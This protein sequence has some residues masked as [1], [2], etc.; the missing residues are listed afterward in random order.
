MNKNVKGLIV[1]GV[2]GIAAYFGY[3]AYKRNILKKAPTVYDDDFL[4]VQ[5]KTGSKAV[6][7]IV[8]IP[9]N[10]G[11]NK[12]QFYKNRRVFFFD[13]NNKRINSGVYSMGG[14][15]I[16]LDNGTEIT[17]TSSVYGVLNKIK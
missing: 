11:K 15:T 10:N 6:N 2:L 4:L 9:Y 13:S 14:S 12:A 7:D 3:K 1:V 17:D 8:T 16:K 5:E